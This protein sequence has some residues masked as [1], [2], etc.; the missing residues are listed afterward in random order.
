MTWQGEVAFGNVALAFR[1]D[2]A[3]NRF[4][5]HAA[6]QCVFS[7]HGTELLDAQQRRHAGAGWVVRSGVAHC[8]RPATALTLLLIE[9]QSRLATGL[10]RQVSDEPIAPL[11]A[12]LLALLGTRPP[13][14]ALL[15]TMTEQLT[16][17]A[18]EV[19]KRILSALSHL[20]SVEVRD[21]AAVAAAHAGI[22]ASRLRAL[23]RDQ[24]GVPFSTLLLWRKVRKACMAIGMGQSLAQA[25]QLAGFSDQSHLTRTMTKVIGLT[26]R[27]A[28]RVGG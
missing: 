10:L 24:F 5:A 3:E 4:H 26:P 19:D 22:S 28:A 12:E 20:D 18:A 8:L 27:E 9:P 21:P 25:A 16:G 2:S 17:S 23:C 1:G 14:A 7:E 13:L 15:Q 6:V 11:P